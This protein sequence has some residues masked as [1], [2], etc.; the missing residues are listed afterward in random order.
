MDFDKKLPKTVRHGVPTSSYWPW[1]KMTK[2]S[3]SR[4]A[5]EGLIDLDQ[6]LQKMAKNS[7]SRGANEALIDLDQKWPKIVRHGVPTKLQLTFDQKWPKKV[8]HGV[9]TKF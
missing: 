9:P 2:N 3:A 1:P 4:G 7:A 5:N 8:C 6:K